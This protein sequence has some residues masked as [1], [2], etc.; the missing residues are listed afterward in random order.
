M[1]NGCKI[2]NLQESTKFLIMRSYQKIIGF[3]FFSIC[4]CPLE[5]FYLLKLTKYRFC[6]STCFLKINTA[7]TISLAFYSE[8]P[9]KQIAA[10]IFD[11]SQHKHNLRHF[12][13]FI[14]LKQIFNSKVQVN[15]FPY[16]VRARIDRGR[17][18]SFFTFLHVVYSRSRSIQ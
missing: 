8:N 9:K 10:D 15:T 17:L 13:I 5:V 18:I 7:K 16:T 14:P 6:K 4:T 1:E 11:T 12:S 2:Q 3:Q